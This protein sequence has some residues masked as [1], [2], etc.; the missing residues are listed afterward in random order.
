MWGDKRFYTWNYALREQFNEKVFKVALDAGFTCPNR[1]GEVAIGG[2]TFCSARGSGDFAG[3]RKISLLHQFEMVRSKMHLKWPKAKYLAY[4]QAFSNTYAPVDVL[5]DA[6]ESVLQLPNVVGIMIATRPDCLPDDVVDY[7]AELNTRTY[8]W[9]EL[10]L[11][12]IHDSTNEL[13]NRAHDQACFEAGVAKLRARGIRVCAHIIYGLPGETDEMMMQTL[14]ACANMDIQGIKIH[15]L[16]LMRN[17]PMVKQWEA[18]LVQ[19]LEQDHYIKLVV[20]SLEQL[21][22]EMII[23]RIT[24]DAPRETLIG[25]MWSLKK[26]EVLNAIDHELSNRQTYQGRLWTKKTLTGVY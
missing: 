2:C 1:D 4:F 10:G 13:I 9:V 6:Y 12:S 24:G 7:L 22:P 8:L 3:D 11:Q 26:W 18:G 14:Q 5:R 20:E 25:P 21:P 19:F 15:L 17:T 16:H 23:H